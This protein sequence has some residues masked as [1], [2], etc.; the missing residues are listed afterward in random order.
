M[1]EE[2]TEEKKREKKGKKKHVNKPSS[3]RWKK[4]KISGD[5]IIKE[6]ECPRC[7]AG[8]FLMKTKD[9][10]YCGKCHYTEFLS[11]TKK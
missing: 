4:Y 5:K 1:P 2:R 10:L 9:R 8:I 11:E 7:G 3:Q 6:R